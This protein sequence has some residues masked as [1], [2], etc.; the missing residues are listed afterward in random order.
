MKYKCR[1]N[2]DA[3]TVIEVLAKNKDEALDKGFEQF[4]E[5]LAGNLVWT[6]FE[7]FVEEEK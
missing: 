3:S 4:T 5:M 2:L 7:S 1:F 6:N